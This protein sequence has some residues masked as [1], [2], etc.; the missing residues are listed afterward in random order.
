M[1]GLEA[2]KRWRWMIGLWVVGRE[3]LTE[4]GNDGSRVLDK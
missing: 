1:V 2:R 4:K 3:I